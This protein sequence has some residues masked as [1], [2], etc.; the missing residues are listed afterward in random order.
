MWLVTHRYP[1]N[2][3]SQW[4]YNEPF[5][6]VEYYTTGGY[7][8]RYRMFNLSQWMLV[9]LWSVIE[10][11][12]S[13]IYGK[14]TPCWCLG[15]LK[16]YILLQSDRSGRL[17]G[18]KWWQH[19]VLPRCLSSIALWVG[20]EAFISMY[21]YSCFSTGFQVWAPKSFLHFQQP[22]AEELFH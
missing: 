8:Y 2:S 6:N 10:K 11:N 1:W 22:P 13:T 20:P 15:D 18:V 9:G 5:Q 14:L 3:M 4:V 12:K 19:S 21:A 16:K 17:T 7:N